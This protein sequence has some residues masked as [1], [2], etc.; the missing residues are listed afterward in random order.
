MNRPIKKVKKTEL[1][2]ERERKHKKWPNKFTKSTTEFI[3]VNSLRVWGLPVSVVYNT[4]WLHWRK[5]IFF[6]SGCQFGDSFLVRD[7]SSCLLRPLPPHP[8]TLS[9]LRLYKPCVDC[10]VSVSSQSISPVVPVRR[11]LHLVVHPLWTLTIFPSLALHS[12]LSSE[13]RGLLT[14]YSELSVSSLSALHTCPL[15]GLCISFHLLQV[16]ASLMMTEPEID[17]L[18]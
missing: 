11:C 1:K 2:K 13:G 16:V 10:A 7:G 14:C 8:R 15:V 12:S 17:L 5:L 4:H 18:L 3:F 6:S 9:D